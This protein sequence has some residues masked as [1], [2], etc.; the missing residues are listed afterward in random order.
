M[1]IK[2]PNRFDLILTLMSYDGEDFY[3]SE[4]SKTVVHPDCPLRTTASTSDVDEFFTWLGKACDIWY[5]NSLPQKIIVLSIFGEALY[6]TKSPVNLGDWLT[7]R[8]CGLSAWGP[9]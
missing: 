6:R 4:A 3:F 8:L 1:I 7:T 5:E 9:G 2:D